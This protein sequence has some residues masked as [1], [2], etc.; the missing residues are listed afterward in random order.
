MTLFFSYHGAGGP[1]SSTALCLEGVRQMA[2][3]AGHQTVTV[4]D[5]V[6]QNAAPGAKAAI[7][8]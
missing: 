3:P 6:H 7:Y 5:W 2:V 1:E 8:G 4:F